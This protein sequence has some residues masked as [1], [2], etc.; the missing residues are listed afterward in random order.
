MGGP[1]KLLLPWGDLTVIRSTVLALCGEVDDIVVVTGR[2]SE[3][4]ARQVGDLART[5]FNP[6]FELGAGGS[7]AIGVLECNPE[8]AILIALGDM[9]GLQAAVV[10]ALR[11]GL[12]SAGPDAIRRPRYQDDPDVPGHPVLFGSGYRDEMLALEGDDGAK[13]ILARHAQLVREI[14]CPG[15]LP[16]LDRLNP[17]NLDL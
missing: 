8:D 1:N 6:S 4:V 17:L 5:V 7:I 3:A 15:C 13:D 11:E 9:P 16:D 2:D 10:Q 12:E 14:L